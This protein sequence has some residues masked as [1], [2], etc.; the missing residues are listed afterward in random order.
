MTIRTMPHESSLGL[1]T[2]DGVRYAAQADISEFSIPKCL[3]KY[4]SSA[5]SAEDQCLKN[6]SGHKDE[7]KDVK[8]KLNLFGPSQ[9]PT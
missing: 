6:S 2:H 8:I 7:R 4:S 9:G 3:I 5:P 1:K